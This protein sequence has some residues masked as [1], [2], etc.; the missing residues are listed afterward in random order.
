M[1][2]FQ[3][4]KSETAKMLVLFFNICIEVMNLIISN[5]VAHTNFRYQE[6]K[7]YRKFY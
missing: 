4:I 5:S 6:K 3:N 7:Y 1:A 2:L